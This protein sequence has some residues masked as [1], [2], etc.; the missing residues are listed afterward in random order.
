MRSVCLRRATARATPGGALR[1]DGTPHAGVDHTAD[2]GSVSLGPGATIC[3]AR[4]RCHL[5]N[6]LRRH[7]PRYENGGSA[8]GTAIPLAKSICG[9]TGG[10]YPSRVSGPRYRVEREIVA[11]NSAQLF[12]L[13]SAVPNAFSLGQR[14]PGAQGSGTAGTGAR[15]SDST[16]RGITPPI[17]ATRRLAGASRLPRRLPS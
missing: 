12:C 17:S 11:T 9:T 4:S 7:D 1:G 10:L 6:R 5:R 16:G 2:A 8:Y 15:G 14:C 13:L 3:A